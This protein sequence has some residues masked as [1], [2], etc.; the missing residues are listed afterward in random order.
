[1]G[2]EKITVLE[3]G[4]F[5]FKTY[6]SDVRIDVIS[7]NP[8]SDSHKEL[9]ICSIESKPISFIYKYN[10]GL[11]KC[12]KKNARSDHNILGDFLK[13]KE[14]DFLSYAQFFE[15]NGFLFPIPSDEFTNINPD[16][17]TSII[18]R[19][20]ATVELLTEIN[21]IQEIN[22]RKVIERALF[23]YL[24]NEW[25]FDTGSEKYSSPNY[26]LAELI[27]ATAF[28]EILEINRDQEIIN[29]GGFIVKDSINGNIFFS[30]DEYSDIIA[31]YS[32][33]TG[34]DDPLFQKIVY[35]YAN[36][37]PNNLYERE[38]IDLLYNY[39]RNVGI[40]R[41]FNYDKVD[42]YTRFNSIQCEKY[43]DEILSFAK[44]IIKQEIDKQIRE[45]RP[46]YNE[47]EMRPDWQ[48]SSLFGALY[49]SLFFIDSNTET[50]RRCA[51]CGR[52]FIVNKSNSIKIYCDNFCRRNA[53]AAKHRIKVKMNKE[54]NARTS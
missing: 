25:H 40:P 16:C 43:F 52:F 9:K 8:K 47:Q 26:S 11:M 32:D 54:K 41:T 30:S 51:K 3:S 34:Y 46:V 10:E 42:Y 21:N 29:T 4:A 12:K 14:N 35:L 23:L 45:V 49:F 36:Y 13:I 22:L 28:D 50:M 15:E 31:G 2:S 33:K 53:Q 6:Q 24:S 48:I 5:I 37:Q 20:K 38:I 39:Y 17:I 1:M 27:K 44:Y 7:I 19:L 18:T